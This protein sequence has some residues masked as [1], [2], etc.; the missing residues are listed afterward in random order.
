[1][2][3]S[4]VPSDAWTLV[5]EINRRYESYQSCSSDDLRDEISR[6]SAQ[7]CSSTDKQEALDHYLPEVFAIVKDTAR[8]FSEGPIVVTANENDVEQAL[9]K[10]YISIE[11]DKAIYS[12]RWDG[13]PHMVTWNMIHYDEQLLA[14]VL[15]HRGYAV[16]M[17]TGE[18]KT[19]VATLPVFL[20]A[21]AHEGVHLITANDYLSYRD[22][23]QMSPLYVLYG[24]STGCIEQSSWGEERH[25]KAYSADITFGSNSTF[26]FDYLRNHIAVD[27]D[28]C[29][30]SRYSFAVVDELD[31]AFIDNAVDPHVIGGGHFYN[32]GKIYK[33]HIGVIREF[34]ALNEDGLYTSDPVKKISSFTEKG[35]QWLSVRM[36][37]PS[38]YAVSKE[39]EI[40]N[41]ENLVA[42]EKGTVYQRFRLQNVFCQ[43]LA[44]LTVYTRDVDYVVDGGEVKII[45]PYTGRIK[46][47]SRWEHG[48]HTAMEVK[49]EVPVKPDFDGLAVISVKN[50]FKL[51]GKVA[52][53]SGTI[54]SVK[55]ELMTTYGLHCAAVPTHKPLIRQDNPTKVF[56]TI[57]NKDEAVLADVI[58][59]HEAGR[60]VL[61]GCSTVLRADYLAGQLKKKDVP[62][63]IL[64]AKTLSEEAVLVADAGQ[65]NVITIAT[66]VA[67]RGTDIKPS[68]RALR[69]GGLRIVGT[70]LNSSKRIDD[71]LRGRSGRQGNPGSSIFYVSLEDKILKYLS[72]SDLGRLHT[73]A[74]S[75]SDNELQSDEAVLGFF[76]LAQENSEA[77]QRNLRDEQARKDDI[78][79][80]F[81]RSFYEQRNDA[82]YNV[83]AA[84]RLVSR[85]LSAKDVS[86]DVVQGHLRSLYEKARALLVK[87]E[88][89]NEVAKRRQVPFSIGSLVYA[90]E[91]DLEKMK[92]S[93]DYF[94]EVY[95]RQV[96]LQNYD[97]MWQKLVLYVLGDLDKKEVGKMEERYHRMSGAM[98]S[99]I[100]ACLTVADI[101]I[102]GQ[103]SKVEELTQEPQRRDRPSQRTR[104][105]SDTL[106]PCGSGKKYRDCHGASHDKNLRKRRR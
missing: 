102:G 84:Q 25:K 74:E 57:E 80:P 78:I 56:R 30:P 23:L 43:L 97:R 69:K 39:Y 46:D 12:N 96:I 50:Y 52:G 63:S 54:L 71:Q 38:L 89:N 37:D 1:M 29:V 6:I 2:R 88:W 3:T 31:S 33:E 85:L 72:E 81:R 86:M 90:V 95:L 47:G 19:L 58:V 7:I 10:E 40:D 101:P 34:L 66:S 45:D 62:F 79:A 87:S 70:D 24:L 92:V 18:G 20:N 42:E 28:S 68:E 93:F 91:F 4:G 82:L 16:E 103:T 49:E 60:P 61:V 11:G 100:L 65:E 17:A 27:P 53:M 5:S 104:I 83:A 35:K 41:Y 26:I 51:Y 32:D 59:N 15:L 105:D 36:N 76:R 48:L 21:L 106:C 98:E 77:Y 67:G 73:L 44:A 55:D 9:Q 8:R 13:G 99:D 14:G 22:Y 94:R 64:D 75:L